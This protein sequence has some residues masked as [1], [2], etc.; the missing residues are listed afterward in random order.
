MVGWTYQR[1]SGTE[2]LI[3]ERLSV[4]GGSF[5]RAAVTEVCGA[6]PGRDRGR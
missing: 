4:F 6:R 5:T 2:Q 3:F 1:L